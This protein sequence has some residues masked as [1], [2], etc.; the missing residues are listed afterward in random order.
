MGELSMYIKD[1]KGYR[2]KLWSKKGDQGNKWIFGEATI[3]NVSSRN[4]QVVDR[5]NEIAS[6]IVP[7]KERLIESS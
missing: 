3:S 1:S 7:S 2:R 5:V 6:F 4:Y